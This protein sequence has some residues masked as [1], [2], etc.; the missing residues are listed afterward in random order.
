M[1]FLDKKLIDMYE[2]ILVLTNAIDISRPELE[3]HHQKVAYL[4]FRIGEE[5]NL[6]ISD[7]KNLFYAGLLH[8]IGALSIEERF[9]LIEEEPPGAQDHAFRGSKLLEFVHSFNEYANIIKF[10]HVP[11]NNGEGIFFMGEKVPFLS[12]ILHLADRIVAS[13]DTNYE[14]LGQSKSIIT[15]I[16]Q[17]KG[18]IFMPEIVDAFISIS[19]KE[20]V[21]L[22]IGSKNLFNIMP[23]IVRFDIKELEMDE[24]INITKIFSAIIDFYSSFTATHSAG[25]AKTA[26]KLAKIAGFSDNE[27]KMILVAGYLHDL[28]K[29]AVRNYVL[30][31]PC[32][33]DEKEIDIIK[34]HPYYTYRL[35]QSIKEFEIINCW[36]SYH[37]E[38]LNG[39]G[40]PFHLDYRN[41]PL[42][43]RI[44]SVADIFTAITEDRPYRKGMGKNEAIKILKSKVEDGSICDYV[45]SILVDN[46]DSI[47]E[48]R[49]E[50]QKEDIIQEIYK[51]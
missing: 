36:A 13:L 29:L 26:E 46:F 41:I 2:L 12:H 42:G 3:G 16:L 11:W 28:G 34:S 33:L 7:Q 45:V 15:K 22:D 14:I 49:E 20:S 9:T 43:S 39:K 47:N 24:V 32:K 44:I 27:C 51:N 1:K 4:A 5:L 23:N 21:W 8:D 48:I 18:T 38:K 19:K 35:L 40:Y 31:K 6:L 30:E 50:A 25:V 10:H 37:H 17:Q